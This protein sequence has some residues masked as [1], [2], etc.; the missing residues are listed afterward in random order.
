MCFYMFTS[1]I[2]GHRSLNANRISETQFLSLLY[3]AMPS[4]ALMSTRPCGVLNPVVFVTICT[5]D[6][7]TTL[8]KD[9][10]VTFRKLIE[11]KCHVGTR[12]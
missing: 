8:Y 9:T 3:H 1:Q 6:E 10:R 5:K 7:R 12:S 2:L 11:A 4:S